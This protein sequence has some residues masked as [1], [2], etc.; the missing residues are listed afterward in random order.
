M[1]IRPVGTDFYHAEEQTDIK[2]LPYILEYYP[3]PNVIRTIA[4]ADFLNEKKAF[5]DF[6]NEKKG[7]SRF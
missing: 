5:A 1:K 2:K 6:L 4:F 3:H 7:F